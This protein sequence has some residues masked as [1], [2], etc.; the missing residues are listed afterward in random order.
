MFA[1]GEHIYRLALVEGSVAKVGRCRSQ[2]LRHLVGLPLFKT[3]T[4]SQRSVV[5]NGFTLPSALHNRNPGMRGAW[6]FGENESECD[7][8]AVKKHDFHECGFDS[9]RWCLVGRDDRNAAGR[10]PRLAGKE[11]D[12]PDRK[13]DRC[14]GCTSKRS[15]H[16]TGFPMSDHRS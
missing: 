9:R 13:G 15:V 6:D 4:F 2:S 5:V 7:G 10:M 8:H 1:S 3:P 11:M 14:Q 16:R 12:S